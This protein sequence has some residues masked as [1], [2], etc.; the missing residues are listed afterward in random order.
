MSTVAKELCMDVIQLAQIVAGASA[1][2][3][4]LPSLLF[5]LAAVAL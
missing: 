3:S 2:V 5:T 1:V 4:C